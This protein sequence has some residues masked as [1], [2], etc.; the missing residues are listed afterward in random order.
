[1]Q[2]GD[3]AL[4]HMSQ[5]DGTK[6]HR[7]VLL[8][9]Q[10]RPFDDW[11]VC[12][13]STQLHQEVKGFDHLILDT[14]VEFAATGFKQSSIIRLGMISTVSKSSMPGVIGKISA[15]I[16]QTLKERLAAHIAK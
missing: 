12:A 14:S 16:L 13:V 7:P 8:L 5:P 9:K 3:V 2:G 4:L 6:K 10:V 11:I 15:T 1:M